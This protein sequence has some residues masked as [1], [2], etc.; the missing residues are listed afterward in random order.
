MEQLKTVASNAQNQASKKYRRVA[1]TVDGY[2][3]DNP[4]SAIGIALALGTLIGF[5]TARR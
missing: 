1:S 4:W 5:F 2:V 3:G